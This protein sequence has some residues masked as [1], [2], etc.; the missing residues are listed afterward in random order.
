MRLDQIK[1]ESVRGSRFQTMLLT[2][3]RLVLGNGLV[4]ALAGLLFGGMGSYALTRFLRTVP[5]RRATKV[6]PIVALRYD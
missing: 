1:A 2:L 4:L 3:R 6:D 5:A